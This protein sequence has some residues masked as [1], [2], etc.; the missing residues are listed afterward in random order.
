MTC[1]HDVLGHPLKEGFYHFK[2]KPTLLYYIEIKPH[3]GHEELEIQNL[4]HKTRVSSDSP[5]FSQLWMKLVPIPDPRAHAQSL[6]KEANAYETLAHRML[7]VSLHFYSFSI[8]DMD[9][10]TT[11]GVTCL[12]NTSYYFFH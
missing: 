1:L 5:E 11:F 10:D 9:Q 2:D 3:P 7:G 4:M 6:E 8:V 12:T